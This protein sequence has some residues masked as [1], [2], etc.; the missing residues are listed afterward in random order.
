MLLVQKQTHRM[1]EQPR[2]KLTHIGTLNLQRKSKG[3]TA[4]KG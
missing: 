2:N 1:I 3:H 4:E